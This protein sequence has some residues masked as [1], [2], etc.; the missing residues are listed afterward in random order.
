MAAAA[1]QHPTYV[2]GAQHHE[3]HSDDPEF[4]KI[5]SDLENAGLELKRLVKLTN[6]MLAEKFQME[7]DYLAKV[8]PHGERI[9]SCLIFLLHIV[10]I[11]LS[12][13]MY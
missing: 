2:A 3:V 13:N 6:A 9:F 11:L 1:S 10:S 8:R 4:W 5:K 12:D 7:A